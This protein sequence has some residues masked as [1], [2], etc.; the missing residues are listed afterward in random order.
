MKKSLA[1]NL[2]KEWHKAKLGKIGTK[3]FQEILE[4]PDYAVVH[5]STH[6]A[7][8]ISA[9]RLNGEYA[10]VEDVLTVLEGEY[11]PGI[12]INDQYFAPK[13]VLAAAAENDQYRF[14]FGEIFAG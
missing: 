12:R 3:H 7:A 8:K 10:R 5:V 9:L 14:T 4:A 13:K 11:F 6:T 2:K 1:G